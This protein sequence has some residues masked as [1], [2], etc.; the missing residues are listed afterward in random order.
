M[1]RR[2]VKRVRAVRVVRYGESSSD[3]SVYS[4]SDDETFSTDSISSY[5]ESDIKV[6]DSY[7]KTS[8]DSCSDDEH[9]L[10]IDTSVTDTDSDDD[11]VLGLSEHLLVSSYE[12]I[13]HFIIQDYFSPPSSISDIFI[14][15]LHLHGGFSL[16]L[17]PKMKL[18]K[19]KLIFLVCDTC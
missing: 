17:T 8:S 9:V 6:Q 7:D 5:Y 10:V 4:L 1:R 13:V 15:L 3:K 12:G 19:V 2:K 11:N 18:L 14:L 16:S